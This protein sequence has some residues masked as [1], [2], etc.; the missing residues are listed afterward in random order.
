MAHLIGEP[1]VPALASA[2]AGDYF[3]DCR[4]CCGYLNKWNHISDDRH[5]Y[6]AKELI[7]TFNQTLFY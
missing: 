1:R 5:L 7:F 3:A 6:E 2:G 4:I